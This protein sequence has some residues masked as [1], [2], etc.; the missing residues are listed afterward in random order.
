MSSEKSASHSDYLKVQLSQKQTVDGRALVSAD[1]LDQEN[2][3]GGKEKRSEMCR[4]N[5]EKALSLRESSD[6][7]AGQRRLYTERLR[8]RK[9]QPLKD[10]NGVR[11]TME[12]DD[13]NENESTMQW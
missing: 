12:Y 4:S 6:C 10:R 2:G 5:L 3:R 7:T 1:L 11:M 8:H 13:N 9:E